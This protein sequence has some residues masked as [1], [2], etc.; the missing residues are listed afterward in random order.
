MNDVER[1]GLLLAAYWYSKTVLTFLVV[2]GVFKEGHLKTALEGS[3]GL[4]EEVIQSDPQAREK[5]LEARKIVF[6]D[7]AK[8][9]AAI[10]MGEKKFS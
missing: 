9:E 4:L 7:V 6:A 1:D 3:L 5:I 10:K 2:G 8:L